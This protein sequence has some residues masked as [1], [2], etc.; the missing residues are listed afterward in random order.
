M[1]SDGPIR[2]ESLRRHPGPTVHPSYET[3]SSVGHPCCHPSKSTL[4]TPLES[5]WCHGGVHHQLNSCFL[6]WPTAV[7]VTCTNSFFSIA[8]DLFPKS[9]PIVAFWSKPAKCNSS[10]NGPCWGH[11]RSCWGHP[12]SRWGHPRTPFLAQTTVFHPE[13]QLVTG[14]MNRCSSVFTQTFGDLHP[15]H[16]ASSA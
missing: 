16:W 8:Q 9:C 1:R 5:S 14:P 10:E 3:V 6:R 11:P 12:R 15:G 7:P 4:S 2:G 13:L